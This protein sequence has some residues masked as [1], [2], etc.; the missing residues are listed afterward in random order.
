MLNAAIP[1]SLKNVRLPIPSSFIGILPPT[2]ARSVVKRVCYSSRKPHDIEL[3]R[4]ASVSASSTS[5]S[6][7]LGLPQDNQ[8]GHDLPCR[9]G[10]GRET[11]DPTWA[12]A[13]V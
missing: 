2:A 10:I 8:S 13:E 1:A 3:Q 9:S 4:C 11:L 12:E 6:A 7:G 5:R